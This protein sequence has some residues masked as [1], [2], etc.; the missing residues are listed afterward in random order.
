MKR[1]LFLGLAHTA[2]DNRLKYKQVYKIKEK[3]PDYECVYIGRDS[4]NSSISSDSL[5]KVLPM[6]ILHLPNILRRKMIKV[7][8]LL[9]SIKYKPDVV[10][11]SDIGELPLG[12]IIKLLTKARLIY[13]SHED[14]FNQAYEY[15]GKTLKGFLRGKKNRIIEYL[16]ARFSDI[17]FCTDDYLYKLYSQKK[18]SIKKLHIFHNF[19]N[20]SLIKD[21]H[22][23]KKTGKLKLVYVGGVN[24]KRGV[25]ECA[26]FCRKYNNEAN[27]DILQFYLYGPENNLIKK[28]VGENL[29]IYKGYISSKKIFDILPRYDV[30]VCLLQKINKFLRNLP[31]KNFEYMSVGLPVLTSDFGNLKNYIEQSKA[32]ICIDPN[33]YGDF[34]SAIDKLR[35]ID[36]RRQMSTNG[37]NYSRRFLLLDNEIKPYL[38]FIGRALKS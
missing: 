25:I 35:D 20:L 5:L 2:E 4:I 22:K 6:K 30:G 12:L 8:L 28:L 32:G 18:F 26:E 9:L 1:I 29:A 23:P 13:D 37:I 14:Y 19:S 21:I 16:L 31:I 15:S 38:N 3:F 7:N 17:A 10:Q 24:D 27:K 34:K 11:A 36:L 33:S